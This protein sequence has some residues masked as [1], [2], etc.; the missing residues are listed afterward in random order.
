LDLC[1]A[2]GKRV[3]TS[4]EVLSLD[5]L[6][7]SAIIVGAGVVGLEFASMMTDLGVKV[8]VLEAATQVLAALDADV[9]AVL[10]KNLTRRGVNIR[11]GVKLTG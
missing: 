7:A 2:D 6:P 11:A 10:L 9:V 5:K 8:T 4:D 1:P 3:L